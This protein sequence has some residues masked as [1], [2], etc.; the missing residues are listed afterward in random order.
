MY[1]QH[2]LSIV[3]RMA[4][5]MPHTPKVDSAAICCHCLQSCAEL[6]AVLEPVF[7]S[8]HIQKLALELTSDMS[9]LAGSYEHMTA[10]REARHC[11]DLKNLWAWYREHVADAVDSP[12][13]TIGKHRQV[14]L[15]FLSKHLLGK[16]L[17]KSMQV[18]LSGMS[19]LRV[20]VPD[21][22][23]CRSRHWPILSVGSVAMH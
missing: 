17:D 8:V 11:L 6:S 9:K 23:I 7:R 22:C 15:S 19:T 4:S 16:P 14:G 2:G 3:G 20:I 12:T 10:F 1:E 18:W 5:V 13:Q 21:V